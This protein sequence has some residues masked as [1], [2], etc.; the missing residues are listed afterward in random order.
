M[1]KK[2]L[3]QAGALLCCAGLYAQTPVEEVQ[4]PLGSIEAR[5]YNVP[6][7]LAN[8][9]ASAK[10]PDAPDS[11]QVLRSFAVEGGRGTEYGTLVRGYLVAPL[12]GNY[13]FWIASD[14]QGSLRLSD[15]A[16]EGAAREI[17]NVPG[18]TSEQ[19][20]DRY[21]HQRSASQWLNAG[22]VYYIE[23]VAKQQGGG[24]HLSV[25]WS[26]PGFARQVIGG[27]YLAPYGELAEPPQPPEEPTAPEQPDAVTVTDLAQGKAAT[28]SSTEGGLPA[29]LANDGNT[30]TRWAAATGATGNW[31]RVDLGGASNL[32][33]AQIT[34]EVANWNYK[35]RLEVSANGTSWTTAV[36]KTGSTATGGVENLT[37]NAS[38]VRYV[39][40]VVT[41]YG[42]GAFWTSIREV[43]VLGTPAGSTPTPPTEPTTPTTPSGTELAKG[44]PVTSSCQEAANPRTAANDGNTNTRWAAGSRD[45]AGKWWQVDLGSNATLTGAQLT[46]DRPEWVD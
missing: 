43:K 21:V 38:N 25:A 13:T 37:F 36:D 11:T 17:C 22:Q 31:W 4:L 23:A 2:T 44:K 5:F 14:D 6:G 20:F 41:G 34:W 42:N 33:G 15:S 16:D 30:S 32:T 27:E 9:E 45:A 39:R 46:W 18:W 28:A 40:V 7:T 1:L 3:L 10:Y 26:G 8:L 35:Y 12:D 24:D 29:S 19:Q